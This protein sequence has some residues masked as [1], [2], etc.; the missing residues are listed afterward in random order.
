VGNVRWR[1]AALGA[2][3]ICVGL[4]AGC[5]GSKPPDNTQTNPGQT[6]S[7]TPTG[8][9]D[10]GV[11]IASVLRN[12]DS[13]F[14]GF[15]V[16]PK[17]LRFRLAATTTFE[18]VVCGADSPRKTCADN[19]AAA[20]AQQTAEPS[21]T[22]APTV[23]SPPSATAT[24]TGTSTTTATGTPS[25]TTRPPSGTPTTSS[26]SNTNTIQIGGQVLVTVTG[27]PSLT[28]QSNSQ[29][30][31]PVLLKTESASWSFNV[32]P[33]AVGAFSLVAH[34]SVLQGANGPPLLPEQ[35]VII[36]LDVYQTPTDR[37]TSDASS[38][39]KV[40][41]EVAAVLGAAGISVSAV[42][43]YLVRRAR[44]RRERAVAAGGPV[45]PGFPP[46]PYPQA[47]AGYPPPTPSGYPAQRTP[48][49]PQQPVP[50]SAPPPPAYPPQQPPR[51][52]GPPGGYPQQ[53]APYS[54]IPTPPPQP[55][56]PPTRPLG[57]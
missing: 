14:A 31:Q 54:P 25:T 55:P 23:G 7:P 11:Y 32:I 39:W 19:L 40:I 41:Q 46:S 42:A 6:G 24:P 36:P 9:D 30:N 45:P 57:P 37:I 44:R 13:L 49:Y 18:V 50:P 17:N 12:R 47:R 48:A 5:G 3:M 20:L 10:Q 29:A 15:V 33:S 8:I 52:A 51:P 53:P 1:L 56:E 26:T 35:T 43:V 21:A 16:T 22:S 38:F 27:D 28:I 4:V 2:A 34:V